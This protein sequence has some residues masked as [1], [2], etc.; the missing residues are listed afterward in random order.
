MKDPYI[1]YCFGGYGVYG[2]CGDGDC[3]GYDGD[4]KGGCGGGGGDDLSEIFV[5][6][7]GDDDSRR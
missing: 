3:G 4:G 7:G 2:D 5:R 6:D 1:H